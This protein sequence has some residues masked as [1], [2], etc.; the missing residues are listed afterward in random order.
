MKEN[1]SKAVYTL[2]TCP[3]CLNPS[4]LGI[5]SN[6]YK[7]LICDSSESSSEES[8]DVS[9]KGSLVSMLVM[10]LLMLLVFL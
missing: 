3:K 9:E 6:L 4:L 7:C 1:S 5:D 2:Y 10:T 8:Q